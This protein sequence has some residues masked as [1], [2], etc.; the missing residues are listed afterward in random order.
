MATLFHAASRWKRNH[1]G[2]GFGT[3]EH[4]N[5]DLPSSPEQVNHIIEDSPNRDDHLWIGNGMSTTVGNI[6]V[7]GNI[8]R[9]DALSHNTVRGAA[10]GVILL[11]EFAVKESYITK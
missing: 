10:G 1:S 4:S 6:R 11:A 9:F 5:L 7:D 3:D 2:R 8:I